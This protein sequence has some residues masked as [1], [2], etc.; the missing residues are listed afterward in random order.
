LS[1][2]VSLSLSGSRTFSGRAVSLGSGSAGSGTLG[3]AVRA[4]VAMGGD[5]AWGPAATAACLAALDAATDSYTQADLLELLWKGEGPAFQINSVP[6][7]QVRAH[8]Y[9]AFLGG[10]EPVHDL[11]QGVGRFVTQLVEEA[12]TQALRTRQ[13]SLLRQ[14]WALLGRPLEGA[15]S[16]LADI[17]LFNREARPLR[18]AAR[19]AHRG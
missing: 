19:D 18:L 3:L 4:G 1:L 15:A 8:A 13:W 9:C 7:S 11:T 17:L 14:M 6:L 12:Y 10:V 16:A 2:P 5:G